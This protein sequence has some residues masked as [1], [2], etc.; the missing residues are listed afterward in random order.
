MQ[1]DIAAKAPD[2]LVTG[3]VVVARSR[4]FG[5]A[6]GVILFVTRLSSGQPSSGPYDRQ[7]YQLDYAQG[8]E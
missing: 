1:T 2:K 6:T 5:V 7:P 3:R 8:P 4:G